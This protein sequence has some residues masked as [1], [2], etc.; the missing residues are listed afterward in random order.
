MS[1]DRRAVILA[2]GR[3]SRL[4]PFTTV[5]PKP[6]MPIGDRAII[7][8]VVK[9]LHSYGFGRLTLAVGYLAHLLEAVLGDG[10]AYDLEIGY[11]HEA[12]PLGTAG[13]LATID[14]LRDEPFLAMNGDVLTTLD[15]GAFMDAHLASGNAM[16]VAVHARTVRTNYGVLHLGE[17]Q[18]GGVSAVTGYEEKPEIPYTVSM[19]VYALSPAAVEQIPPTYFDVPDLVLALLEAGKGVGAYPFDGYWLDIGRHDDYEQAQNDYETILPKL[20]AEGS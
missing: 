18:D 12:E 1:D 2:G 3:G 19:G 17:E 20:V 7:E 11:H 6:L 8:V 16:T 4:A 10:S 15:Y 14:G 9:Q 13:P 5:L